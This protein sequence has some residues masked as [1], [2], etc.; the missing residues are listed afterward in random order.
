VHVVTVYASAAFVII[1]LINNLAEPLNLPPN[2]LTVVVIVLAIGF[3]M[4]NILSWLYDL[5]TEGVEKTAVPNAWKIASYVSFVVIIGLVTFN[6]VDGT[7]QLHARDIQSLVVLPFDNYTGIDELEYYVAGMHSGLI[8]DLG[9][10]SALRVL[11]KATSRFLKDVDMTIPEIAS[12]L[13]VDA[14][15]EPSISCIGGDS[16]CLQIKLLSAF[17]EEQQLWVQDLRVA[18]S[19]I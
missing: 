2:L 16:I 6:I 14:V 4:A 19:Q 5:T 12:E 3:P 11:S 15:I 1:E 17:P 9:K 13:G 18:K 8:V 7:K 10:I